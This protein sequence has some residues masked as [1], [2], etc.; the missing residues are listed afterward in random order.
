VALA[1]TLALAGCHRHEQAPQ[2]GQGSGQDAAQAGPSAPGGRKTPSG[3]PVP[4]YVSLKFDKVNAR[5]GPDD[6]AKLL[7]VY[8][9][10]G[11]PLQVVA[12]TEEWRRVCDSAGAISWVHRR[13]VA[14]HR[15]VLRAKADGLGLRG[16]PSEA[17][18]ETAVL[19]GHAVADLKQC[20]DDWC[21]VS[22][23]HAKGWAPAAE[24]WGAS[25]APQCH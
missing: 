2:S 1:A 18:G 19:V 5:A 15:T 8:H 17:A 23:G 6:D 24:L 7:Y 14:E 3:Q 21:E 16:R 22:V 4:R 25:D 10:R 9:A 12:E 11:L 13:T 20:K